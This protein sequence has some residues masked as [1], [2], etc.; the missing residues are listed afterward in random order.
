MNK[1]L[2]ILEINSNGFS[3]LWD[4]YDGADEY[5]IVGMNYL[6]NYE[7][8]KKT[9]KN[10]IKL[11]RNLLSKYL[12]IKV[13]YLHN[14]K[15][16]GKVILLGSSNSLELE[17][18]RLNNLPLRFIKSFCG[19]SVSTTNSRMFDK[20]I[21]YKKEN[22][23]YNIV[24]ES[25]DFIIS[26]NSIKENDI[27]YMEAFVK[28]KDGY[29][30]VA[31]SDDYVCKFEKIDIKGDLILSLIVPVYN[32]EIY[33]SRCLDSLLLSTLGNKEIIVVNDCS[34]DGTSKVLDWYK[35]EYKNVIKVINNKE[36]MGVSVARNTGI[37]ASQGEYVGI[38]DSDDFVHCK[39]YENLYDVVSKEKLDICISTTITKKANG[40]NDYILL[41][42]NN[43]NEKYFVYSYDEMFENKKNRTQRN[44]YFSS[45][46]NKIIK[47]SLLKEHLFPNM[48]CYEDIAYTRLIYSYIDKFGFA[49]DSY[50]VWDQRVRMV[51]DTISTRVSKSNDTFYYH[52]FYS[53]IMKSNIENGNKKRKKQI[54][55]D[56]VKDVYDYLKSISFD[57]YYKDIYNFYVDLL[58]ECN[59]KTSFLYNQFVV[60]DKELYSFLQRILA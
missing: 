19:V 16:S 52:N 46:C 32:C 60:E 53:M 24:V 2:T 13:N 17:K 43:K 14:D 44:I 48:R 55:Y 54:V 25:E 50:Y 51:V 26:S 1:S 6:F 37:E 57:N 12:F 29:K 59:L 41:L 4:K 47:A 5:S 36:N 3:I 42:D 31:S 11:D 27:L 23:K 21:L 33:I 20:Y 9:K 18:V 38:V 10:F 35:K 39:M 49:Y 7:V 58:K 15:E 30:L 8:I 28:E 22:N 56:C 40:E 34:S 45:S